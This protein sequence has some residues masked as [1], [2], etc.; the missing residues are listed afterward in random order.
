MEKTFI[1][2]ENHSCAT[3]GRNFLNGPDF[4]SAASISAPHCPSG[5]HG[6]IM[7]M[8]LGGDKREVFEGTALEHV[9]DN[10]VFRTFDVQLH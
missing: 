1:I 6:T 4:E 2:D 7:G 5:L 3:L 10:T 9:R 8:K